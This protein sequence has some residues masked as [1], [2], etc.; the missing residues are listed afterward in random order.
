MM[1]ANAHATTMPR[2]ARLALVVRLSD[3][4]LW[5]R[6]ESDI[7]AAA[8]V[9]IRRIWAAYSYYGGQRAR[10]RSSIWMTTFWYRA[11]SL[12]EM[13]RSFRPKPYFR[14]IW[15]TALWTIP[16]IYSS[17]IKK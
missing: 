11:K 3:I 7:L 6:Y 1:E 5:T 8:M 2:R 15:R 9:V 4:M 14:A 10:R 16:R 12:A 17:S 13:S